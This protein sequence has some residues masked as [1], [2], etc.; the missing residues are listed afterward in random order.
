[1]PHIAMAAP[2]RS[3]TAASI[4]SRLARRAKPGIRRFS[5]LSYEVW[6]NAAYSDPLK[7]GKGLARTGEKK[8]HSAGAT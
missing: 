3:E 1:M 4:Q 5:S 8:S 2:K 6:R 7:F